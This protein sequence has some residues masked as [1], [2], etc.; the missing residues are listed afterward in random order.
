MN[1]LQTL[2]VDS[3]L[4]ELRAHPVNC[5]QF[6]TE[7]RDQFL[8][9]HQL[10]RFIEQYHFFCFRFVKVLEG[11]LYSTPLEELDM[12]I[13][14]TKTLHSELGNGV[15]ERVHI[16]HL[17]HFAQTLGLPPSE[18]L[19]TR[20]IP[21]VQQYLNKLDQLFRN[22]GFLKALGA[23]LA[24]EITAISEFRFFVPGLQ[25]YPQFSKKDLWFFSMHLQEEANHSDWLTSAVR[26]TA[27][28]TNDLEEIASGA[29]ETAEAWHQFWTGMRTHVQGST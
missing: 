1:S 28:T 7:F 26:K 23:E 27:K 25:K 24:V 8:P 19:H 3:L 4:D 13:E 5:N 16:R 22:S 11:L 18:L 15:K 17:E 10:Q 29:R 6:F 21:E 14:L 9:I 20:P 12:R 2:T